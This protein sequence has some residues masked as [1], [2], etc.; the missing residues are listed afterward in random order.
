D[1]VPPDQL[2]DTAAVFDE[3]VSPVTDGMVN[4][5]EAADVEL[6]DDEDE[7]ADDGNL[8]DFLGQFGD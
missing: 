7:H 2:A 1:D 8:M 3:N 5:D 6:V 4:D